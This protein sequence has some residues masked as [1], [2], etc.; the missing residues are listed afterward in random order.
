MQHFSLA[1]ILPPL[2][3]FALGMLSARWLF[4]EPKAP[5]AEPASESQPAEPRPTALLSRWNAST[6]LAPCRQVIV[7]SA[8][9]SAREHGLKTRAG[10]IKAAAGTLPAQ[11]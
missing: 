3:L 6:L 9:A 11:A 2:L 5:A 10:V 7:T 4:P 8:I 1:R